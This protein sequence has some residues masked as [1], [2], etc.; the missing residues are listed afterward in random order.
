MLLSH[1]AW[2]IAINTF[3]C[4]L[5]HFPMRTGEHKCCPPGIM[6]MSPVYGFQKYNH[7][8]H[9]MFTIA[10]LH[11]TFIQVL[12]VYLSLW[13]F[14]FLPFDIVFLRLDPLSRQSWLLILYYDIALSWVEAHG[15][16][17]G[18]LLGLSYRL[19][20]WPHAT[21]DFCQKHENKSLVLLCPN[22]FCVYL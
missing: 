9:F 18:D 5:Q 11:Y 2:S 19:L 20:Y 15:E 1:L 7:I 14:F 13:C 8:I 6:V 22:I 16:M 17:T 4:V 10:N 12:L 3:Q 21:C